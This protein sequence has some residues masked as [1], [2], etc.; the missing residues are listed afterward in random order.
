LTHSVSFIPDD[1]ICIVGTL[2]DVTGKG[3]DIII[4]DDDICIWCDLWWIR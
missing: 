3:D 2:L 1:L 4:V